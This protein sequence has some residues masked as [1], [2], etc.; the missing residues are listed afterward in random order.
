MPRSTSLDHALV[1][2]A[3]FLRVARARFIPHHHHVDVGIVGTF[4][5]RAGADLDEYGVAI[6]AVYQAMSVRHPGL[7][8]CGLTGLERYFAAVLAQYDFAF[9]HVDQLVFLF[10]P[11][12]LRRRSARSQ[13]A[14]VDAELAESG[15]PTE[16]LARA[17]LHRFVERWRIGR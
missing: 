4:R 15:C 9:E 8:G 7:P 1:G 16:A 10:V 2:R 11:M 13:R 6:A 5:R 14:D 17:P 12:A 3:V